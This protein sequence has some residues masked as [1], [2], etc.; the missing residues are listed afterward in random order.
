MPKIQCCPVC[1]K[2]FISKSKRATCSE[3]CADVFSVYKHKQRAQLVKAAE[4]C[5]RPPL[6]DC[7]MYHDSNPPTCTGLT[8]LWCEWEECKFYKPKFQKINKR[9]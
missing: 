2:A 8:A 3:A 7:R 1:H 5:K 9:K 6:S 4:D